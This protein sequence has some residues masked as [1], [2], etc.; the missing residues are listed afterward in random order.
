[1]RKP[2]ECVLHVIL[3]VVEFTLGRTKFHPKNDQ[4]AVTGR[5]ESLDLP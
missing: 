1:V 4:N 2:K 5:V 3:T